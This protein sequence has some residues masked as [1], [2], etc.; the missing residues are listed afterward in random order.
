MNL[1]QDCNPI[2]LF[3]CQLDQSFPSIYDEGC[4]MYNT[5]RLKGRSDIDACNI[6]QD[7]VS[8]D[9]LLDDLE[10]KA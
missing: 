8:E 3:L 7:M 10:D 1:P 5:I 9:A 6:Y 4:A 2:Q